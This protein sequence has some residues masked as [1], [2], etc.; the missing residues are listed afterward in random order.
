MTISELRK[1]LNFAL[2]RTILATFQKPGGH[3]SSANHVHIFA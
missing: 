2:S 3:G 1:G